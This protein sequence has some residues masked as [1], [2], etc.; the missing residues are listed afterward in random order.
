MV[1]RK[2]GRKMIRHRGLECD[3]WTPLGE[4]AGE[5]YNNY[6][7]KFGMPA[8]IRVSPLAEGKY[9]LMITDA[10]EL[11][12]EKEDGKI[13]IG[14]N[15]PIPKAGG[16]DGFYI[17]DKK[18]EYTLPALEMM[19]EAGIK[20]NH[21]I[22][23]PMDEMYNRKLDSDDR[24]TKY[25]KDGRALTLKEFEDELG[26]VKDKEFYAFPEHSMEGKVRLLPK[27][28]DAVRN[29]TEIST[30]GAGK[31]TY[32]II[33]F[34]KD[35]LFP[36][37]PPDERGQGSNHWDSIFETWYSGRQGEEKRSERKIYLGGACIDYSVALTA[38]WLKDTGYRPIIFAPAVKGLG[39]IPKPLML[40]D[41]AEAYSVEVTWDWPSEFGDSP[42]GWST[43]VD[44]IREKDKE[45]FEGTGPGSWR[46]Y[47]KSLG[48]YV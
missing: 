10:T 24:L 11:D 38:I 26:V 6:W 33:P 41:L 16:S 39:I 15:G 1:I 22:A 35:G 4:E 20:E 29:Q 25:I 46:F 30:Y 31:S 28:A 37:V 48:N 18:V 5:F 19:L 45:V 3:N 2:I 17:N 14:E 40:R 47:Q 8:D 12:V 43:L 42:K 44:K 21:A 9:A 23:L 32:K 7:R 13:V 27:F 36:L 34:Q